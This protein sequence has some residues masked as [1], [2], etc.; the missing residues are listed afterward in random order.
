MHPPQLRAMVPL[1]VASIASAGR[2][3]AVHAVLSVQRPD[4]RVH[5]YVPATQDHEDP[6]QHEQQAL[7]DLCLQIW[8]RCIGLGIIHWLD[9]S[10]HTVLPGFAE[11][12]LR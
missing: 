7:P 8:V 10:Q 12:G 6:Q 9:V 2:V 11:N 1:P 5:D 3:L 4:L